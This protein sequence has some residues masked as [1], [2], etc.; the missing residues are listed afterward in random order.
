MLSTYWVNFKSR[1]QRTHGD[2][3]IEE[4]KTGRN[5]MTSLRT[6]QSSVSLQGEQLNYIYKNSIRY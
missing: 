2:E 3:E 1:A 5:D 4:E 6:G